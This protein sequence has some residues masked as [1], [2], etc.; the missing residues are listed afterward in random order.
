MDWFNGTT[1]IAGNQI[2]NGW[3]ILDA[4]IILILLIIT[5]S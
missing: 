5:M 3:I 4:A 1:S 2:P